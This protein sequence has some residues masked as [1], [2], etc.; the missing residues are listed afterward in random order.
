MSRGG[1]SALERSGRGNAGWPRDPGEQPPGGRGGECVCVRAGRPGGSRRRTAPRP[2]GEP[3]PAHRCRP[4]CFGRDPEAP[5]TPPGPSHAQI[6][7]K[8]TPSLL[9]SLRIFRGLRAAARCAA[10]PE[11]H[12][13]RLP[14]ATHLPAGQPSAPLASRSAL[15]SVRWAVWTNSLLH[16][17]KPRFLTC[18]MQVM[19]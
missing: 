16:L 8:A 6:R 4:Q 18:E 5:P 7:S 9:C 19:V 2:A 13:P 17:S 12:V 3:A 14:G 11:K 1:N 10:T 15:Q